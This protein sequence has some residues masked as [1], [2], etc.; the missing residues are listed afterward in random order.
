MLGSF[1]RL[2]PIIQLNMKKSTACIAILVMAIYLPF[3]ASSQV[4]DITEAIKK[5]LLSISAEGEG[6]HSGEC[7]KLNLKNKSK[8]KLEV[9]VPAGQIFEAGDSSL[10]NLM[11]SKEESFLVESGATRIGKL[12]GFCIEASDGSPGGGTIFKIGKLADGN[13]LK[14]AKYLNDN[15]LHQHPS[16]QY[17]VWAVTDADRLEGIG[18]PTLTKFVADMLGKPMPEYHIEY[19]APPQDRILPGQPA[20]WR[21]AFAMNGLFY[22]ELANDQSVDFG[23]YNEAGELVHSLFKNRQQKRGHHKFRFEFE[24]KGLQKGKYAA[25]LTNRGAVIKELAVEF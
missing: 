9:R 18:D 15:K 20:N 7:L 23:L 21:E 3:T 2:S 19:K 11:V 16:A 1:N 4:I 14:M 13:L 8:K 10:Q 5:G 12:F 6:G 22:Y 25:K 17:A 24:I